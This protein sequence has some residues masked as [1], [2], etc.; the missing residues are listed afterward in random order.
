M[1]M[2]ATE[3]LYKL[4]NLPALAVERFN[5]CPH[6]GQEKESGAPFLKMG[7]PMYG[8]GVD[9]EVCMNPRCP[10]FGKR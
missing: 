3:R 5:E 2:R 1:K 9:E 7:E 4:W 10:H 8:C 6:C